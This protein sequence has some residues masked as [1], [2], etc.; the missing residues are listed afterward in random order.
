M[1]TRDEHLE[2]RSEITQ[3][4]NEGEEKKDHSRERFIA[5]NLRNMLEHYSSLVKMSLMTL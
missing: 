4:A 2:S 3:E 1:T 5:I